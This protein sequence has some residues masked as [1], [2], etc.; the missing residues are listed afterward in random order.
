M[1][2][3]EIKN[4]SLEALK[5]REKELNEEVFELKMKHALGQVGNPLLLRSLRR[6]R[7]QLKTLLSMKKKANKDSHSK[8]TK[9]VSTQDSPKK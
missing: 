8:S 4:L 3:S 9:E 1:K 6:D 5:K 7:A 2:F